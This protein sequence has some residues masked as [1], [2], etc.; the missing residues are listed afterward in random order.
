MSTT[1]RKRATAIV[2]TIS[3]A[4]NIAAA[5]PA[6]ERADPAMVPSAMVPNATV[7]LRFYPARLATTPIG[8]VEDQ[9][10]WLAKVQGLMLGAPPMLQ[11]SLLMSQTPEEFAANVA[12]LQQIQA[13]SLTQGGARLKSRF[14]NG[15]LKK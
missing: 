12:L 6:V 1:Q 15:L 4:A 7:L 5:A 13:T 11:Q 8:L 3:L 9:E 14:Q 2:M 10:V